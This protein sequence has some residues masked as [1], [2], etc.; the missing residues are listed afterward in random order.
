LAGGR[1]IGTYAAGTSER[2][3][4]GESPPPGRERRERATSQFE[5]R[6]VIT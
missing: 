3:D 5:A 4:V 2:E 6:Y 1:G